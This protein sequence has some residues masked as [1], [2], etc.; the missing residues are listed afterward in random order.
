MTKQLRARWCGERQGAGRG[1]SDDTKPGRLHDILPDVLPNLID[2]RQREPS[3]FK[4]ARQDVRAAIV[5]H[6]GSCI[7][8]KFRAGRAFYLCTSRSCRAL[9]SFTVNADGHFSGFKPQRP[10]DNDVASFMKCCAIFILAF[11][12]AALSSLSTP[13]ATILS[14]SSGNGRCN[15][16]ASSQGARIQLSRSSSVVRITGIAFW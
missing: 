3:I 11:H 12:A 1:D 8:S 14:A 9:Y 5:R 13:R 16:L 7:S 4:G 6:A 2:G 10:G 15:A